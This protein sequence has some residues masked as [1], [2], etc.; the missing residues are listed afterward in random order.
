MQWSTSP[1]STSTT[2]S[3]D[4]PAIESGQTGEARAPQQVARSVHSVRMENTHP[5]APGNGMP[6]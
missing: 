4:R 5:R 2:N 6:P 3:H 1:T